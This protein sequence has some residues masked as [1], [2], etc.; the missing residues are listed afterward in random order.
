MSLVV[1]EAIAYKRIFKPISPCKNN[2]EFV[3]R[4][5]SHRLGQPGYSQ[6]HRGK[7]H[8]PFR[9]LFWFLK[10]KCNNRRRLAKTWVWT[11]AEASIEQVDSYLVP[12]ISQFE[13]LDDGTILFFSKQCMYTLVAVSAILWALLY[14]V[15]LLSL[16]LCRVEQI[17]IDWLID[18]HKLW[19]F[20]IW[21]LPGTS[22]S[23]SA[24]M[25]EGDNQAQAYWVVLDNDCWTSI[26][27]LLLGDGAC[28]VSGET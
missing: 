24:P 2:W 1:G 19:S 12:T 22:N 6:K 15:Q 5:R 4:S 16:F 13:M 9:G 28:W 8:L 21:T 23:K 17:K 27:S 11:E 10:W 25:P 26:L 3:C 20:S 18:M 14:F 7:H